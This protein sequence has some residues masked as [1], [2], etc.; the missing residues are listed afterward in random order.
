MRSASSPLFSKMESY[1]GAHGCSF[2]LS[3][4]FR[5]M[6]LA[7]ITARDGVLELTLPCNTGHH[8]SVPSPSKSV[9]S[10][11]KF[12]CST[13]RNDGREPTLPHP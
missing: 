10:I 5:L 12:T 13:D 4:R 6:N 7:G 2:K 9:G 11:Y 3:S 1:L 8:P